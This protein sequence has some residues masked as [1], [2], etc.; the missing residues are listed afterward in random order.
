MNINPRYVKTPVQVNGR[1]RS[2]ARAGRGGDVPVTTGNGNGVVD[3]DGTVNTDD[4]V[5]GVNGQG[6]SGKTAATM[7]Y[8][9]ATKNT[10]DTMWK[11]AAAAP[12]DQVLVPVLTGVSAGAAAVAGGLGWGSDGTAYQGS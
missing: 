2:P 1:G 8:Q 11:S 4:G 6:N 5:K 9:D 3:G 12:W 7:V 10:W